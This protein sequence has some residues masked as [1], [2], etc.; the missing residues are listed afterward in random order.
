MK[1]CSYTP[2]RWGVL[3]AARIAK[4]ALIPAIRDAGGTVSVVASRSADKAEA[5]ATETGTPTWRDS[6]E[7]VL[8][9]RN[10]DA[11]YIPL[12]ASHHAEWAIKCAKAGKPV[13]CEKPMATT[14]A[15]GRRMIEAFEQADL[16]LM[17]ATMMRYHPM[18]VES[19]RI[20][21]S[22]RIGQP[23]AAHSIFMAGAS[24]PSDIRLRKETGGGALLDLGWYCIEILRF[25]F[26]EPDHCTGQARV[27]TETGVDEV[28]TG[29][30]HWNDGPCASFAC[31]L[32][33]RFACSYDIVGTEGRLT[34]SGGAMVA[35]AGGNHRIVVETADG[36]E[37]LAP[38]DANHY[39]LLVEAFHHSLA[40][41]ELPRYPASYGLATLEIVDKLFAAALPG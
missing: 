26:G 30:L 19:R 15:D 28:F 5:F 12:P 11:V 10:V 6:Y 38:Q 2:I 31:A 17:D 16:L 24:D 29:L 14:A 23:L 1:T 37:H 36:V 35:W 7:A 4:S 18:H 25:F 9:D 40:T 32:K 41:G 39:T 13:L 3:G 27:G 8:E 22:G 33:S 21:E 34:V 20:L